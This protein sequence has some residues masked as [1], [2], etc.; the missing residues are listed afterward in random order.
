[1]ATFWLRG[2]GIFSQ[3]PVVYRAA[4]AE[5]SCCTRVFSSVWL[6]LGGFLL[7]SPP[8]VP[9][10][11]QSEALLRLHVAGFVALLCVL[12]LLYLLLRVVM[13]VWPWRV[14]DGA[15]ACL[16]ACGAF[17]GPPPPAPAVQSL[18]SPEKLPTAVFHGG[19][20]GKGRGKNADAEACVICSEEYE[21]GAALILL[22]CG[23][24]KGGGAVETAD[25]RGSLR[26]GV[27]RD[28]PHDGAAGV[29]LAEIV[30]DGG[31]AV[32]APPAAEALMSTLRRVSTP[33]VDLEEHKAPPPEPALPGAVPPSPL[34]P[35]PPPPA[36]A[37]PAA[38]GA[39]EGASAHPLEGAPAHPLDG[40]HFH[41]ACLLKWLNTGT[42]TCPVCRARVPG[43]AEAPF[44]A[45]RDDLQRQESFEQSFSGSYLGRLGLVLQAG[46]RR[47]AIAEERRNLTRVV[48][49]IQTVRR[50]VLLQ[51]GEAGGAPL[52]GGGGGELRFYAPGAGGAPAIFDGHPPLPSQP[53]AGARAAQENALRA[54]VHRA[55]ASDPAGTIG[56][57][58]LNGAGET[59]LAIA[60]LLSIIEN[61][62]RRQQPPQ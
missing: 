15:V 7:L 46:N 23:Q 33:E 3:P 61:N 22:P 36:T 47:A 51:G 18:F 1:M 62:Q 10:C 40:H 6:I 28:A 16:V 48:G 19:A 42:P 12:G 31:G 5:A 43:A 35:P 55:Y 49:S 41:A 13:R 17:N 27:P 4:E 56:A 30:V 44:Q 57:L 32:A 34:P 39:A 2:A 20:D 54:L 9:A 38:E 26:G 14:P 45:G 25:G 29:G 37:Q 59:E 50:I 21:E 60:I 11:Q 52:V 53:P 8:N 58:E 24:Q